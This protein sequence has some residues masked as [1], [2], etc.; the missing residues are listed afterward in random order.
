MLERGDA[1]RRFSVADVRRIARRY[2]SRGL[3]AALSETPRP[4][5]H[6]KF[7]RRGEAVV[8]VT[9]SPRPQDEH[10]GLKSLADAYGAD[11]GRRRRLVIHYTRSTEAG[12]TQPRSRPASSH[13]S[14]WA[15]FGSP[16]FASSEEP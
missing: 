12:R 11:E 6:R 5:P 16:S 8:V 7:R 15:A 2:L 3:D 13:A 1:R 4:K 14:A 10:A 9:C